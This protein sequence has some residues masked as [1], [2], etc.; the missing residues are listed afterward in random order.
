[1]L[2]KICIGPLNLE[3]LIEGI[4][5]NYSLPQKDQQVHKILEF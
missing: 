3:K 4:L 5:E 2:L 1:M